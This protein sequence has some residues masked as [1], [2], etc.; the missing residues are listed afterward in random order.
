VSPLDDIASKVLSSG[1]LPNLESVGELLFRP[2][3]PVAW[4]RLGSLGAV[5]FLVEDSRD[6][7]FRAM[8]GIYELEDDGTWHELTLGGNPWLGQLPARPPYVPDEKLF[9]SRRPL[10]ASVCSPTATRVPSAGEALRSQCR[11]RGAWSLSGLIYGK[12]CTAFGRPKA[13]WRSR[14]KRPRSVRRLARLVTPSS[15]EAVRATAIP[16]W[17]C[18]AHKNSRLSRADRRRSRARPRW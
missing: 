14:S 6:G 17:S 1:E 16:R 12:R 7:H 8:S 3:L 4:Q 15:R 18:A 2:P 10:R 5:L 9:A 11:S 13:Q